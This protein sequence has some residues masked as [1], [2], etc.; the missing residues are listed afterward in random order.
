MIMGVP[1]TM[2]EV[3][4]HNARVAARARL[5]GESATDHRIRLSG[6]TGGTSA[7]VAK[8]PLTA[9]ST[10]AAPERK[11]HEEIEA[12]LVLRRWY[13]VHSRFGVP[14]TQRP[15]V[16][17]FIIAA[18]EGITLWCEVKK[19]GGKLD[20]KQTVTKHVLLALDHYFLVVYSLDDFS[21]ALKD[22]NL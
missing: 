2:Q 5:P 9:Y 7:A 14:T 21:S 12:V 11:I 10:A 6:A 18:P 19:K 1:K 22:L 17:D 8:Q 13:F 20:E 4:A 3:E 15:G 16:P